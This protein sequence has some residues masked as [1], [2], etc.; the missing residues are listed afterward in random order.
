MSV[1]PDIL[2][3]FDTRAQESAAAARSAT[4]RAM[5]VQLDAA[6]IKAD[7]TAP[8]QPGHTIT[9]EAQQSGTT[10]S[11]LTFDVALQSSDGFAQRV[12]YQFT[13]RETTRHTGSGFYNEQYGIGP[14]RFE[15]DAE[16]IFQGTSAA[17]QVNTFIGFLA[18]AKAKSPLLA[19]TAPVTIL[20][21]DTYFG[22]SF[23]IS[24]T[25]LSFEQNTE[26]LTRARVQ[27]SGVI[28]GVTAPATTPTPTP[29]S[30]APPTVAD[31]TQALEGGPSNAGGT[32]L[33]L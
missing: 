1:N 27:M 14:G 8:N 11:T 28:F 26:M 32:A 21:H 2:S 10:I 33:M 19:A 5:G 24:Q 13:S 17:Q 29:F 12:A 20:L 3:F 6:A 23:K 25:A 7:Q 30:S 15:L 4:Q 16:V 31:L 18:N 9:L 22:Q